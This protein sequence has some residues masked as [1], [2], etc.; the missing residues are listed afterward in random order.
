M[1]KFVEEVVQELAFA[2]YNFLALLF[3]V[4]ILRLICISCLIKLAITQDIF[5][6]FKLYDFKMIQFSPDQLLFEVARSYSLAY[7]V[8][9]N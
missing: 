9:S 4:L 2:T 6:L 5:E 3:L 7:P 8:Q 1:Q